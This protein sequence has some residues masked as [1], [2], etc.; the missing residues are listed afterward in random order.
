MM[1]REKQHLV[2][3]DQ[4]QFLTVVVI[5]CIELVQIGLTN[6]I[7]LLRDSQKLR[8]TWRQII[9]MR[10]QRTW[11]QDDSYSTND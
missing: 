7:E 3:E 1:D 6:T 5:P 9:E 10:G 4:V 2:P 8:D 11:R